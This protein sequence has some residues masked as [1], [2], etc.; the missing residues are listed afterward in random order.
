MSYDNRRDNYMSFAE[1]LADMSQLYTYGGLCELVAAGQLFHNVFEVY[2]NYQL[3]ER[4]GIEGYPVLWMRFTKN[5]SR[6]HFD[7]YLPHESEILIPQRDSILQQSP[8]SLSMKKPGKRRA[9]YTG[10]I[11]KK[12]T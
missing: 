5:L 7:V 9:R 2:C 12:T 8:F 11:R 3:Y 4:F 1:Y 6:G 10:N